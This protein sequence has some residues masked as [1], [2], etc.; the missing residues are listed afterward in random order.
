MKNKK[1]ILGICMFLTV[2]IGSYCMQHI[3]DVVAFREKK[4]LDG[5]ELVLDP[6]H[7]G[8]SYYPSH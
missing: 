3:T 4:A 6:G 5:M 2:F 1:I 7:G 8:L